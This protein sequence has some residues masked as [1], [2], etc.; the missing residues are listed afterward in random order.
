LSVITVCAVLG[1][2]VLGAGFRHGAFGIIPH[3]VGAVAVS[4]LI[5]TSSVL[6]MRRHSESEFLTR[7]ARV[8]LLLLVLQLSLGV[9]AYA[10]RVKAA[11]DPQ[12]LE[13]MISLT[14]AHVVVGALTLSSVLLLTLRCYR[15]LTPAER[16]MQQ[17]AE[18][19]AAGLRTG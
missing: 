1:Q 8:S 19:G 11:G 6:V 4:V 17:I 2:L 5:V 7:P 15:V 18:A 14:A 16:P 12:P 10:A 3:V 13:P 9:G